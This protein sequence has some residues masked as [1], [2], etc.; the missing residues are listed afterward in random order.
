M[1]LELAIQHNT[2]AIKALTAL[3][4]AAKVSLPLAVPLPVLEVEPP[5][6]VAAEKAAPAPAV[7]PVTP[8]TPPTITDTKSTAESPLMTYEVV[9][10]AMTEAVKKDREGV[11]ALLA[12]YNA[13]RGTDLKVDQYAAFLA[14]LS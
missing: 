5:K 13:K 2:E 1:S 8:T 14:E 11:V 9:K 7:P 6:P 4:S 12:K 3:L 10:K